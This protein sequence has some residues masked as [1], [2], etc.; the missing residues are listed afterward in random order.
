[1]ACVQDLDRTP[2][3]LSKTQRSLYLL[4]LMASSGH[5]IDISG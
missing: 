3:L 4:P 5:Q 1:M 2:L